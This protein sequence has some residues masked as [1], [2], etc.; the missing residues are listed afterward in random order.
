MNP[1]HDQ[2]ES[3]TSASA[4]PVQRYESGPASL[5]E[6]KARQSAKIKQLGDALVEAGYHALDEQAKVLGLSRSTTWT[7]LKANHKSSGLSAAIINRMLATPQL[8]P[9][10][11]LKIFEYIE[12]KRTGLFGDDQVGVRRFVSRLSAP[13]VG[14]PDQRKTSP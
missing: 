6:L 5:N 1:Q 4:V 12:E 14:L 11:R 7:I 10:V 13:Q 8:P 3:V 9:R 2:R